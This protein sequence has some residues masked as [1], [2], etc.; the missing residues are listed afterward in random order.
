VVADDQPQ[1][2]AA[3]AA[4]LADVPVDDIEL[5]VGSGDLGANE[6]VCLLSLRALTDSTGNVSGA[7]GCLSDVTDGVELR[8]ELERRAS[9]DDL[10]SCLNRSAALELLEAT[11]RGAADG[12]RGT[13]AVFIDLDR[14]KPVNDALGHAAGD[15]L[16]AIAAERLRS[17]VRAEDRVGRVGGDEFLVICPSV[18]GPH[19]ALLIAQRLADA[20]KAEVDVG[21]GRVT[22]QA[23]VGVAWTRGLLEPD[24]LVAQADRAMYESK[25]VYDSLPRLFGADEGAPAVDRR[26]RSTAG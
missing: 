26:R 8:R 20:L 9:V 10:T 11:L 18:A 13:A 12:G 15:R 14:F 5:R 24:A 16:L 2:R 21:P 19:E 22:L 25:R 7:I 17:A 3:L 4:V 23:S 1:L 6:R